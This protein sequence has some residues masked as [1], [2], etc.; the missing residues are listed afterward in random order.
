[1]KTLSHLLLILVLLPLTAT[2]AAAD[3]KYDI[4]LILFERSAGGGGEVWPRNPGKP[5]LQQARSLVKGSGS[6]GILP[7]SLWRLKGEASRLRS[8]GGYKP[9]LHIA[10]RQP[11]TTRK[12]AQ[13]VHLLSS[14]SREVEGAVKVSVGRFLHVDL[15]LLLYGN[16]RMQAHRRLRSGEIHYLDH[17]KMGALVIILPVGK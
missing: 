14:P 3:K 9:L 4:E 10:W 17:P 15:D 8:K 1:M 2:V 12:G 5:D 16:Y 11:V 7:K 6:F 13:A